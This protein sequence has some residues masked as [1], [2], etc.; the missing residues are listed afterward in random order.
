MVNLFY[1]VHFFQPGILQDDPRPEGL[2]N[3]DVDIAVNGPGNN[4]AGMLLVVR[5]KVSST[6]S[7]GNPQRTS[8]Y[9]HAADRR[10]GLRLPVFTSWSLAK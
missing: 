6:A 5:R 7:Q 9:D 4:K 8:G 3:R 1:A 2:G 10:V